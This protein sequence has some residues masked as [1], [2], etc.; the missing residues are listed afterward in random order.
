[1]PLTRWAG[2]A[3][4]RVAVLACLAASAPPAVAEGAPA[5]LADSVENDAQRLF[6]EGVDAARLNLWEDARRHFEEAYRLS[7]RLVVLINLASAQAQTGLLVE[8]V[9]NY[10]RVLASSTSP[11]TAEFRNAANAMLPSLEARTPL[12]RVSTTGLGAADVVE[13]DGERIAPADVGKPHLVDPGQHS[14]T[15]TRDGQQRARIVFSV[16]EGERHDISLPAQ[17]VAAPSPRPGQDAAGLTLSASGGASEA[18]DHR[19]WWKSPWFWGA[20]AAVVAAAIVSAVAYS[21]RPQVVSGNIG[22]GVVNVP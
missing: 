15:V 11:E 4:L 8:A 1:M 12:V 17:V 10:R 22:P 7:P 13:I 19:A 14:M 2:V 6:L 21:E 3:G 5:P 9:D 18:N 16:A 20:T